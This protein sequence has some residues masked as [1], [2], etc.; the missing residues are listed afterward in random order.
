MRE[1]WKRLRYRLE[2]LG[3]L[4][5]M[6]AMPHLPRKACNVLAD[7]VGFVAYHLDRRGRTV[8]LANLEAAF[9][10]H[11][12]PRQRR[13]IAR[14]SFQSFARTM[15]NLFWAPRMTKKNFR[16][17]MH[18][19]NAEVFHEIRRKGGSAIAVCTHAGNFEWANLAMGFEGLDAIMVA[20]AFKN[21]LVGDIF[22]R[23]RQL[24]GN[25]VIPQER[26]AIRL[27]KFM[28][29]G[30]SAGM[31]VDLNLKPNEAS[32]VIEAFGMKMCVTFLHA[33]LAQR[34]GARLVPV[35]A[36]AQ[37]DGTVRLIVSAPLEI[38]PDDSLQ[39]IAQ[40]CWDFFEPR[41][42]EHPHLWIWSYKHWRYKP[43]SAT[44]PY[45]FYANFS[46]PFEKLLREQHAPRRHARASNRA[47]SK[48]VL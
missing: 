38:G 10:D 25:H 41:L 9:G 4:G 37:P 18:I 16:Q 7:W 48:P 24:S 5:A 12:T 27:L 11:Y 43:E 22:F 36:Q 3:C 8:A 21:P 20:Q 46:R 14:R 13:V 29:K 1:S 30:G 2:Y 19:E 15:L 32:T 42:R 34:T 33:A 26:S 45:P 6:K 35:D 40:D 39:K 17:F 47:R 28:A 31:L 44:R 23:L